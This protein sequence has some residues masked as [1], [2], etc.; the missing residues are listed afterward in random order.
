MK[1][2]LFP[3]D[4]SEA[5]D[6]AFIYALEMADRLGAK[7]TTIHI[8]HLPDVRAAHVP[9]MLRE[10]YESIT[11][12]SFENYRDNVPH[13]R[14]IAEERNKAHLQIQ[15][16]MVESGRAG[17]VGKLVKTARDIHAGMIIMGTTG[18]SGLKEI[19][20]G[21]VAA[22]IL[23]NAPC[24]VLAVPLK[25]RF[26]G[27]LDNIL[28][29]TDYEESEVEAI[30]FVLDFAATYGAKVTCLHVD[31]SH[32]EVFTGKM[33]KFKQQFTPYKNLSFEVID[34][35]SIE[36]GIAEFANDHKVDILAM[37]IHKRTFLQELFS[38]SVTKRMAYHLK[39]PI[40]AL[41]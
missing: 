20:L 38:Y 33:E 41:K 11:L 14:Q 26:D 19:F 2:I 23:E 36:K 29:T 39:V 15:H 1:H 22:E 25:A 3:T 8:Y 37:Q 35:T 40:L 13:L 18:A 5:A 24:P 28:V 27:H 31:V 10:I 12:E 30:R 4:F 7:I 21:S 16:M 9:N 6:N 17:L 34:H 32:T